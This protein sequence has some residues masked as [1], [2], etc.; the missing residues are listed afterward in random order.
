MKIKFK[1][2][3]GFLLL[4]LIFA[5]AGV[6]IIS[7]INLMH[8]IN[9][10]V[11]E[12]FQINQYATNYERGARSVQVGTYLI[13]HD[14]LPMGNQLIRE[15]KAQM[16]ENREL[17]EDALAGT[18]IEEEIESIQRLEVAAIQASDRVKARIADDE[19]DP[20]T[21]DALLEQDLHFLE[22]RIEAL[23]LR[24]S[25][26]VDDTQTLME[27]SLDNAEATSKQT[28]SITIYAIVVSI[29]LSLV[30]AFVS[31]HKITE[32]LK[33]LSEV[34]DKISTGDTNVEVNITSKDEVGDLA[35]SFDRMIASVKYLLQM[36]TEEGE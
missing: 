6:T 27:K 17:L 30:I 31:A 26:F 11:D 28:V 13:A 8:S 9:E 21:N 16:E 12:D 15:G 2:L 29:V 7:N 10:N 24:L 5:F 34:A 19:A 4:T 3:T 1:L 35:D 18:E 36:S 25:T 32:P 22:A 20:D 23:N 14:S 33:Q